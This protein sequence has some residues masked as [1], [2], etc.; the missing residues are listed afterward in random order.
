MSETEFESKMAG[1]LRLEEFCN[2]QITKIGRPLPLDYWADHP[3]WQSRI[4]F[5]FSEEAKHK[6]ALDAI[7]VRF[8]NEG[9]WSEIYEQRGSMN[10]LA[11]SRLLCALD[12]IRIV[13]SAEDRRVLRDTPARNEGWWDALRWLL[14]D[15]WNDWRWDTFLKLAALRSL[16]G[17]GDNFYGLPEKPSKLN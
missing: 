13:L 10:F 15:S 4:E 7:M 6:D 12:T 2:E 3:D 5:L 16:S 1:W 14:L 8:C 11:L 17:M 9:S